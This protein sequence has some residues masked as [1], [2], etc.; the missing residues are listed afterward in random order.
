MRQESLSFQR[1]LKGE[2]KKVDLPSGQGG[3]HRE[4]GA[5]ACG[6]SSARDGLSVLLTPGKWE[7]I[8]CC[9]NTSPASLH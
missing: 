8:L 5:G 9:T 1:E 3:S 7:I 2:R 4:A 6:E